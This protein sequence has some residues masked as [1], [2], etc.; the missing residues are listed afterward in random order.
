VRDE[1]DALSD[2]LEHPGYKF[3]MELVDEVVATDT[4]DLIQ[5]TN[6]DNFRF[7]Q[8]AIQRTQMLRTLAEDRVRK[9]RE[10][11]EIRRHR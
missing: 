8:G 5:T 4:K 2:L 11:N 6:V 10:P 9:L 7:F 1:L 3:L